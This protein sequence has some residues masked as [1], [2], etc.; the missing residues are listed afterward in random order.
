MARSCL[1]GKEYK[2]D[3]YLTA[4]SEYIDTHQ[5]DVESIAILLKHP[6]NWGPDALKSLREKLAAARNGL[7]SP[8]CKGH[9]SC[10]VIRP[11]LTSYRW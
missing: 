5:A 6:Q 8:I 2:P 11:W 10:G 3:D 9:S 4:F 7:Q 1:D